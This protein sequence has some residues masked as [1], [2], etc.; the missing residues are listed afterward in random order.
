M[1]AVGITYNSRKCHALKELFKDF[2][3]NEPKDIATY[4][5]ITTGKTWATS[6]ARGYCQGDYVDIVYCADRYKN[7]VKNYGEIWLGCAKEFEV[8]D[9]DENGEEVDACGGYIVA[10]CE[11][12]RDEDYKRRICEWARIAPEETQLEMIDGARTYTEYSYRAA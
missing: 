7:G 6:S 11:A 2:D 8:I 1:I 4:L 9:L 10:D 3:A 5:T 12:W